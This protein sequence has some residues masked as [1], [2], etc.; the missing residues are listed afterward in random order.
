[1]RSL[2]VLML[3]AFVTAVGTYTP[4]VLVVSIIPRLI[5]FSSHEYDQKSV[6]INP[7]VHNLFNGKQPYL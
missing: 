3:S 6:V 2:Q 7:C 5:R 4:F 1:M